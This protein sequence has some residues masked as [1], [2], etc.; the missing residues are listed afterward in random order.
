MTHLMNL[1]FDPRAVG[2]CP[3]AV[4]LCRLHA[5][6]LDAERK[7]RQTTAEHAQAGA[8]VKAAADA[9]TDAFAQDAAKAQTGKLTE[10]L[11]SAE[12]ELAGPWEQKLA[13]ANRNR[14]AAVAGCNRYAADHYPELLAALMPDSRAA[15]DGMLAA[16]AAL[17]RAIDHYNATGQRVNQIL[18]PS[19]LRARDV[20]PYYD[21]PGELRRGLDTLERAPLLFPPSLMIEQAAA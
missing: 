21:T 20:M 7:L 1:P 13:A 3:Q 4:E 14:D 10:A 11:R 5:E 18:A 8:A 15:H 19:P 9:L 2:G 17:R 6:A 16:I 12:A